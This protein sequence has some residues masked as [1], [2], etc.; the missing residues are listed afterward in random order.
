MSYSDSQLADAISSSRSWRGVLRM[1]GLRATSA[2]SVRAARRRADSLGID[3]GHFANRRW[4]ERDLAE[5]IAGADTWNEVL[6]ALGLAPGSNTTRL[7][8]HAVRLGLD[9][10]HFSNVPATAPS[11][12][13]P[14]VD[15]LARAGPLLAAAWFELCGCQV[16]WPLEPCAYDLLVW[17][18]RTA[19]R[20]QVKTSRLRAGASWRVQLASSSRASQ[21]YD[22][23]DVDDLFV[24]DGNGD[25]HLIPFAAV[26]GLSAIHLSAYSDYAVPRL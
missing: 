21:T 16:S 22:P 17:Q 23:D 6:R 10:S 5:A 19:R 8:G 3:Y 25:F 14:S 12:L 24:V 11:E 7:R 20:V 13:S 9:F 1:L 18:D 26:A 2:G 4:T 15:R